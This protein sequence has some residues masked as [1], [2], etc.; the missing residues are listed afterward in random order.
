MDGYSEF[1][2]RLLLNPGLLGKLFPTEPLR[3][4]GGKMGF[5]PVSFFRECPMQGDFET[6]VFPIQISK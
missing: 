5:F 2:D 1:I 4:S 6:R 3:L